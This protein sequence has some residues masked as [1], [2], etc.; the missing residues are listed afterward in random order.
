MK[1]EE[2]VN[3]NNESNNKDNQNIISIYIYTINKNLNSSKQKIMSLKKLCT[4]RN[5]TENSIVI[6][7]QIQMMKIQQII[8]I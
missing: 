2:K 1:I 3:M 7:K 4:L 5:K 6:I 8:I